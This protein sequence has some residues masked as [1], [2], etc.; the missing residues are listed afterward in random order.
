MTS[1]A[2]SFLARKWRI[3]VNTGTTGSPV[4]VQ[5]KGV[6]NLTPGLSAT[7]QDSSD[8]DTDG[9][10]SDEKTMLKWN[11]ALTLLR[12]GADEAT[13]DPGQEA[14]R[15]A[16]D[17]FGTAGTAHVRWYDRNDGPEAYE[18]FANVSW[19][20]GG[21]GTGDLESVSVNLTGKGA[22]TEIVN[23]AA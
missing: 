19:E 13:P 14:L 22:R 9:W 15:A 11:L 8:Y 21:G 23:P 12:K 7:L 3:D 5:V 20:P 4:W 1:P 18:G 2:V 17:Q 16:A 6:T 10:G